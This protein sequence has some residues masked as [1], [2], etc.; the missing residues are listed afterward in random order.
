MK[1]ENLL[2]IGAGIYGAVA[3]EV[4]VSMGRFGRIDFV[5]D[6][7]ATAYDGSAVVGTTSEL[8][9]LSSQ[10]DS[11]AVAIGNSELR[12][13]LLC[14]IERE[15]RFNIATLVSPSA[16]ISPSARIGAGSVVEPAAVVH[17]GASVGVGCIISAGAVINHFASIGDGAHIDCN[18]TVAGNVEVPLGT[19]IPF[20]SV[21]TG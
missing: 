14:K 16:C 3:K 15:K 17:T 1:K 10:Y 20:G 9:E 2:I 5:D 12:L 6:F 8:C 13:S 21:F 19:K 7:S 4:A 11:I 18:A